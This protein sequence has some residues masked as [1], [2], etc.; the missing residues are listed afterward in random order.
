M[1]DNSETRARREPRASETAESRGTLEEIERVTEAAG[2][3]SAAVGEALE[4]DL[5]GG[6]VRKADR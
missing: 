1:I 4:D 2:K 3:T 6:T 5:V